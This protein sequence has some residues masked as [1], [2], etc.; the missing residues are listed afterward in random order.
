MRRRDAPEVQRP[1]RVTRIDDSRRPML[2]PGRGQTIA[3]ILQRISKQAHIPIQTQIPGIN[4]DSERVPQ[5]GEVSN[6]TYLISTSIIQVIVTKHMF[7]GFKD[8]LVYG[9]RKGISKVLV[10]VVG[11]CQTS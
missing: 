10:S 6:R 11:V 3:Y 2:F 1:R 7:I 5:S 9:G 4:T 8:G